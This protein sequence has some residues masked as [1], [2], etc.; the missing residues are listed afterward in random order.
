MKNY[1]TWFF[2]HGNFSIFDNREIVC[3]IMIRFSQYYDLEYTK[4]FNYEK[5]CVGV[6]IKINNKDTAKK[7]RKIYRDVSGYL[8]KIDNEE[9]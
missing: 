5:Q 9:D 1:A 2:N 8:E 7:F 6:S 4:R 3:D